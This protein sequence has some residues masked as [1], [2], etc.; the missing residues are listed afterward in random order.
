MESTIKI[1]ILISMTMPLMSCGSSGFSS[2]FSSSSPSSSEE[3]SSIDYPD[4]DV[5]D[6]EPDSLDGV[7][8][9]DLSGLY[10]A[11]T[12]VKVYKSEIKSYFNEIGL[13]D[14]YRHYKKNYIQESI[15]LFK[16]NECY[17]YT[18]IEE[19][20]DSLNTGY[21]NRDNNY[22][23]F[24]KRGNTIQERL[25]NSI[26][27]SDISLVKEDARY[28]DDLFSLYAL[29]PEYLQSKSF[30]RISENKYSIENKEDIDNFV[31]IC[32]P[33]LDNTGYYMTFKRVTIEINPKEDISFR[34]RLYA[35]TTQSG[36]IIESHKDSESKPNWFM[37]FS[38]AVITM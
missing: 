11:F 36:K 15:S 9:L 19:F 12:D 16:E 31:S 10:N 33:T 38:E 6:E 13:R 21:L 25:D 22:Y 1:I 5:Y 32:A 27:E 8:P 30:E 24:S 4:E 14:Y 18:L 29:T 2:S 7:D 37:L 17:S 20:F 23:S 28:Q 3:Y 26:E 34:F 35:S